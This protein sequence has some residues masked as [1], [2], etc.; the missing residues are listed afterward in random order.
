MVS[1]QPFI[2]F[3][4]RTLIIY[5]VYFEHDNKARLEVN[6]LDLNN[7]ILMVLAIDMLIKL[8]IEYQQ[9]GKKIMLENKEKIELYTCSV[10]TVMAIIFRLSTLYYNAYFSKYTTTTTLFN[11]FAVN[12][13]Y[14]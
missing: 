10:T 2:L 9:G 12:Y 7:S 5:T 13:L 8:L 4:T 3:F 6:M 1:L 11:S 14:K